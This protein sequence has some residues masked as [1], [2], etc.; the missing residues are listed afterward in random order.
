MDIGDKK[1]CKRKVD[2]CCKDED[3]GGPKRKS[4][5]FITK[6]SSVSSMRGVRDLYMFPMTL[7]NHNSGQ[8]LLVIH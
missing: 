2:L 7:S 4:Y 3:C 8:L 1:H 5:V 6:A